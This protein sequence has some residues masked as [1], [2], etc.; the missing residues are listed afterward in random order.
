MA[1]KHKVKRFAPKLHVRRGDQ[2]VV[3]AGDDKGKTGQVLQIFPD[4]NRA[5]VEGVNIV[6]K[7]VKATQNDEGGIREM[8]A[9]IHLSNLAVVD[10]K[11]GE[12]TRVGRRE[13]NGK[14]VRYS[15]KT[16]NIIK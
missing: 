6:K 12:A 13:E 7:H 2:V 4:K 5:I 8:E 1:T 16:G 15:K 9:T 14:S 11:T 10:P 3:L